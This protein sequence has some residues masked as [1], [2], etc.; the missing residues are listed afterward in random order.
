MKSVEFLNADEGL[1]PVPPGDEHSTILT[2]APLKQA[3]S[4]ED[5]GIVLALRGRST[6]CARSDGQVKW[7][8]RVGIDTATLPVRVPAKAPN[9]ASILVVSAERH[10]HRA[11]RGWQGIV[12]LWP[13][14]TIVRPTAG[15]R[16]RRGP[17]RLCTNLSMARFM[18]SS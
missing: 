3:T 5:D 4:D 14:Q 13:R 8:R 10:A 11:G 9:P 12:G 1:K 2:V 16:A 15:R 7:A 18:S 6:L 17:A